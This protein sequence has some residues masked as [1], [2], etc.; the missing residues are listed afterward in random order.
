MKQIIRLLLVTVAMTVFC[1][2]AGAQKAERQRPSREQLAEVQAKH[3][4]QQ[5]AL[6]DATT[7][8]FVDT[9]CRCQKEIWALG[10][11][12]K[13]QRG[14]TETEAGSEQA[15]KERFGRSQKLLDIREKYYEE[16]SKFLTQKQIQRVYQI[17]KRMM[18]R[19]GRKAQ[20]RNRGNRR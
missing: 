17:E 16:Y 15:I 20:Q 8:K 9:Y 5:L 3:I 6:D 4:A 7:A 18:N 11:K 10:P 19:L 2:T 13:R 1:G 14:Q 12:P